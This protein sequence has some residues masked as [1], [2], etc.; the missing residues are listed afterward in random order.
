MPAWVRVLGAL[1]F[2]AAFLVGAR[3]DVARSSHPG[4]FPTSIGTVYGYAFVWFPG[5]F[6]FSG[7]SATTSP[8]AYKVSAAATLYDYC[9]QGGLK[10]IGSSSGTTTWA[11]GAVS[12]TA[13]GTFQDCQQGHTYYHVGSYYIQ[14]TPGWPWEGGGM[15]H[16]Y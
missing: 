4:V 16:V 14:P 5:G 15:T 12:G 1:V 7:S 2:A 9:D 13:S 10:F 8:Y 3:P 11:T 6:V